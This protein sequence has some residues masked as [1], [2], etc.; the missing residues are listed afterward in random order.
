MPVVPLNPPRREAPHKDGREPIVIGLVNNM[1]D[2]ALRI[3]ERQVRDLLARAAGELPVSLR[4]FSLPELPRSE[5]GRLHVGQF[6]E[7]IA[8][9]WTSRV[10]A[11]IVTG[12]EPKAV[13]LE[14]EPYWPALTR[15]VDWAEEHT[16]STI[17]SCLAAHAA[18]HYLDGIE[19]QPLDG[20]LFGVFECD[21]ATDHRLVDCGPPRWCV[22]HSR[23]NELPEEA[24]LRAGYRILT[25]SPEVGAD[26][27]V[28]ERQSLFLFLQGHP[29][30]D[31]TAL[32]GEY[33]R[34]IR[35]FLAGERECYPKLPQGY[36][37]REAAEAML[38]FQER[39]LRQRDIALLP[40]FPATAG[41]ELADPWRPTAT[42]LYANWLTCLTERKD[43]QR[44][45]TTPHQAARL[46]ENGQ[47]KWPEPLQL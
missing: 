2:A 5:A 11:L 20:K 46:P 17:W 15:L 39:A 35:R 16:I 47:G 29:E 6:H 7:P 24:L 9:L 30:Y 44:R 3:T 42:R 21:R 33:R 8:A 18:A 41:R 26:M 28:K 1:P 37:D 36:F 40:N 10:D 45:S 27:F 14:D 22:P 38:G 32:F 43:A 25:R 23:Y 19:R 12:T 4:V 31:A 34:D 13:T